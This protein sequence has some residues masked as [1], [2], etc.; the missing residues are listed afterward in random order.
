MKS[1]LLLSTLNFH[2]QENILFCKYTNQYIQE[3]CIVD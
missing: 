3:K 1:M 2:S